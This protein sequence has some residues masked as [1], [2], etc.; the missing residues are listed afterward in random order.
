MSQ[1]NYRA[2][3]KGQSNN[4]DWL[5]RQLSCGSTTS[6]C[7][8]WPF[9]KARGYGQI[10][11]GNRKI[12]KA[13]RVMCEMAHGPAPTP[14]HEAAHSCG[15]RSCVNPAHLSWKT[16]PNNQAES[17]AM[18]RYYT[19]GR[20]GK[21]GRENALKIRDLKGK[22]SQDKIAEKFGVT[23]STVAKIHRGEIWR[24]AV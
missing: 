15:N 16:R 11:I 17:V 18:G 3:N 13:H 19:G 4:L 5:R 12:A 24:D 23:H 7:I 9:G 6:G 20:R 1:K 21:L 2:W 22:L 14:K 10:G 8:I